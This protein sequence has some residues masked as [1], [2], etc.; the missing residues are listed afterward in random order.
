MKKFNLSAGYRERR[1]GAQHGR[2]RDDDSRRARARRDEG[3]RA[4]PVLQQLTRPDA[5]RNT[6]R[7][8]HVRQA[9][10]SRHHHRPLRD[11]RHVLSRRVRHEGLGRHLAR[12]VGDLGRRRLCRHDH[13][14]A[15][16]RPQGG[17]RSFRHRGR[18][19]GQ[20]AR[21]GGEEISRYRDRQAARQ[22]AVRELQR[23]RSG[24]QLFRSVA[25]GPREPRRS[26]RQGRVEAGQQHQPFRLARARGRSHGGFL[27]RPVRAR[28][29]QCRRA[30]RAATT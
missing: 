20:G 3:H 15:P 7:D 21:Q 11:A 2:A 23:A 14:P 6:W 30:R 19:P 13:H 4:Q 25:T 16:R 10:S 5:A 8:I 26:L 24:R 18:G 9:Q 12:N 22:P 1:R 29:S 28:A 27:R 17:A